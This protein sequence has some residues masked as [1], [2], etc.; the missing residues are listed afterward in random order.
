MI[1]LLD[2]V[3]NLISLFYLKVYIRLRHRVL[4]GQSISLTN[5]TDGEET[6]TRS[7]RAQLNLTKLVFVICLLS[8]FEHVTMTVNILYP[9]HP[10]YTTA[11]FVL[12]S[13]FGFLSVALKHCSNFFVF[14]VF[15]ATFRRITQ[16]KCKELLRLFKRL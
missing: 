12:I 3:V 4:A 14:Y 9:Y 5:S 8:I 7:A 1:G 13:M 16:Q 6:N 10:S 11:S 2:L 15:N